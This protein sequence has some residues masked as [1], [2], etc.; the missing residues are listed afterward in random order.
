MDLLWRAAMTEKGGKVVAAKGKIKTIFRNHGRG[1]YQKLAKALR[2]DEGAPPVAKA[3]CAGG[4]H[5]KRVL[6]AGAFGEVSLIQGG[7]GKCNGTKSLALKVIQLQSRKQ[8]AELETEA[9]SRT[10]PSPLP[11]YRHLSNR[12]QCC[13]KQCITTTFVPSFVPCARGDHRPAPRLRAHS[14]RARVWSARA[15]PLPPP[16]PLRG[17]RPAIR[18]RDDARGGLGKNGSSSR[19]GGRCDRPD[20]GRCAAYRRNGRC[21]PRHQGKQPMIRRRISSPSLTTQTKYQARRPSPRTLCTAARET[22]GSS[23]FATLG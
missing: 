3:L 13:L 18:A 1:Y 14:E 4:W 21:S 2:M 6:G 12:P 10:P 17:R 23:R 11:L 16:R 7:G 8:L 19:R 5:W 9:S 22:N 20:G 15:R